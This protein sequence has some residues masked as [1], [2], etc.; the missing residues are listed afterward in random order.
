MTR[1]SFLKRLVTGALGFVTVLF[2]QSCGKKE[3]PAAEKPAAPEMTEEEKQEYVFNNCICAKC[4]SW[5]DCGEKG[6][7]CL[8]GKS[9]CIKEKKGCICPDCPVTKKMGL[10][11]GYYCVEGDAKSL[12]AAEQKSK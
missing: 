5:V 3:E 2:V 9:N 11:W 4:P 1:R 12:M 10:K 7:F 8:V 6:G